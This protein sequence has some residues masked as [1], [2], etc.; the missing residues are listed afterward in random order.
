LAESLEIFNGVSE[1]IFRLTVPFFEYVR[2]PLGVF[3]YGYVHVEVAESKSANSTNLQ[4]PINLFISVEAI[5][6]LFDFILLCP[7]EFKVGVNANR[8]KK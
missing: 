1:E 3:P 7:S 6:G 4:V 5:L 8:N 2:Y